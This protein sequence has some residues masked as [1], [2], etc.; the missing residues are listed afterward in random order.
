MAVGVLGDVLQIVRLGQRRAAA[1]ELYQSAGLIRRILTF[2]GATII[3][4]DTIQT[5]KS[6]LVLFDKHY[7]P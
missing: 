7:H 5:Q 1:L 3:S 2:E 6:T 4:V